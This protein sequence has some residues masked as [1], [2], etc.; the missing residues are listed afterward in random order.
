MKLS[1]ENAHSCS[2]TAA[3]PRRIRAALLLAWLVPALLAATPTP[4]GDPAS[5][6]SDG[7]SASEYWDLVARFD[8]GHHLF[9]RFLITNEGPG[10]KTGVAYGHFVEPDGTVHS[11]RNGRRQQNWNLG[12]KG[13]LLE[14]GSSDLDLREQSYRLRI[15]KKKVKIDLRFEPSAPAAWDANARNSEPAIDL[16]ANS[17]PIRGSVWFRG[18]PAPLELTGRSA[19]SHTWM[20][21]SEAK[22]ALRRLEFFSLGD[23][24]AIHLRDF[25]APDGTRSRWL[26]IVRAGENLFETNDFEI[27]YEGRSEDSN[28]SA[29][30]PIPRTL[31]FRG[32]T[33]R[34]EIEIKVGLVHHD[35]MQDIPQPFRFLLSLSMRP[36]RMWAESPFGVTVGSGPDELKIHGTGLTTVTYLNPPPPPATKTVPPPPGE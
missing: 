11:W 24:P 4:R 19:L 8:S 32:P 5:R 6:I 15:H 21:R 18:M 28:S 3:P 34:G 20:E 25:E 26:A 1:D 13:L 29:V 17:A 35:P 23:D 7:G 12:P 36:H 2:R 14:V 33:V 22:V 31:R 30:Y 9:A 10:E 27:S 16:L